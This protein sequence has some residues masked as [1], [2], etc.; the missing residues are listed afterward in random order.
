MLFID[1]ATCYTWIYPLK[2]LH[3][4]ALKAVLSTW[5]VD[6]GQ[7]PKLLYTDFDNKIL[8]GPTAAYLH[9]NKVNLYGSPSGRQNQNGLV[10]CAWEPV[11]NMGKSFY[12][13]FAN[14]PP[15]LVLGSLTI[16]TGPQLCSMYS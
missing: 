1:Q 10:E 7:F 3:H 5:S 16:C 2:S 11:T 12:H 4:E 8:E 14:A 6:I 9:A 15:V 13:Q